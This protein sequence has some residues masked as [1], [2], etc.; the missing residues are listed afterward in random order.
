MD[1]SR[2]VNAL[3]SYLALAKSVTAPRAAADII[4]QA[5][6][7]LNTYVFA[8]LLHCQSIQGLQGTQYEGHLRLLELF[9]WGTLAEYQE[10]ATTLN[11]P[12]LSDQQTR[13][14]QLLTL[15]SSSH[16]HSFLTYPA[17]LHSLS[18]SSIRDLEDLVIAAIY[19]DLLDAKLD[20]A[21][22]RVIVSSASCCRDLRPGSL[23]G[24]PPGTEAMDVSNDTATPST[25][26]P[27]DTIEVMSELTAWRER[28]Q[29]VT[30]K[31]ELE[32]RA[33]KVAAARRQEAEMARKVAV[34][35][36]MAALDREVETRRFGKT[37]AKARKAGEGMELDDVDEGMEV[38]ARETETARGGFNARGGRKMRARGR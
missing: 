14:L 27:Q 34:S 11:L 18:L 25:I 8:E 6:S 31:L 30:T 5:T 20:P 21:S 15:L 36:K 23:G 24:A 28:T 38:D 9:A 1:Q 37:K 29:S 17:L 33:V 16:R 4:T 35:E 2:A 19:E 12:S 10:K 3:A 7:A 22:Q 13:K 32:I 26:T